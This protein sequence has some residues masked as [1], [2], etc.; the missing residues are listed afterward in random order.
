NVEQMKEDSISDHNISRVFQETIET[1]VNESEII[2]IKNEVDHLN[3]RQEILNLDKYSNLT[4]EDTV[5]VI[6]VHNRLENLKYLVESLTNVK[7][8]NKSLVIFSHDYWDDEINHF[9][10]SISAFKVM[11]IF[12]P[13]SVQLNPFSY[14]GKEPRGCKEDKLNETRENCQNVHRKFRDPLKFQIKHHWWWK[15]VQIFD[16]LR[17]LSRFEGNV[18]FLEEDHYVFP[19]ILHLLKLFVRERNKSYPSVNVFNLANHNL[20]FPSNSN[21]AQKGS[22]LIHK[23]NF[24][25]AFNRT[26]YNMIKSCQEKFF[27]NPP[28]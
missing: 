16:K 11:Q 19:D 21:R 9:V 6:Q 28:S 4:S 14:P 27:R 2:K 22:W 15:L 8:I 18:L 7:H 17:D 25:F 3:K 1:I 10:R 12:F 26:V 24:G 5:I 23:S 20:Q 13:F